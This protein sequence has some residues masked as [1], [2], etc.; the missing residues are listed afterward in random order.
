MLTRKLG[1]MSHLF[2]RKSLISKMQLLKKSPEHL[3]RL[4]K[5]YYLGK[6]KKSIFAF[7]SSMSEAWYDRTI[8]IEFALT[9]RSEN[10]S[11]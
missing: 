3:L 1:H 7:L 4:K 10:S 8:E 5:I 6:F 2:G 11:T 9:N